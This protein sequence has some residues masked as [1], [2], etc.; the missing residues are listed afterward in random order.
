[1]YRLP[2]GGDRWEPLPTEATEAD[3]GYLV[4]AETPGFSQFVI[5]GREPPSQ[6]SDES[7]AS[8]ASGAPAEG[9]SSDPTEAGESTDSAVFDPASPLV[10]LAAL[11]ALLV[12]AAAIGR[13][14]I[15]RRRDE[16]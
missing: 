6:G 8:T 5:A 11:C 9:A 14:F 13:L 7:E 12:V 16:W 3:G 2:D 15:P 1:V 4:E 10:P